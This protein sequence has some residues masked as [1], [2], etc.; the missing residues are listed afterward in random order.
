MLLAPQSVKTVPWEELQE[1]LCNHYSP[2][3]SRFTRRHAFR[4]WTQAEGETVS[5]YMAAVRTAALHCGFQDHLDDMLLDQLV[6]GVRDL[7]LQRH[8]LT[9]GDL[10]LKMAIE[11]SQAAELSM[12]SAAEI[13]VNPVSYSSLAVHYDEA[14]PEESSDEA[15]DVNHLRQP[16]ASQRKNWSTT[17]Q[18]QRSHPICLSCG[19]NHLRASC[20]FRNAICLKCQK[21]GHLARTCQAGKTSNQPQQQFPQPT[22]HFQ[23]QVED[24]FTCYQAKSLNKNSNKISVIIFLEGKPCKM[25]VDTGSALSIIS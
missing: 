19:G 6:C 13:Q 17:N 20:K 4:R 3:P 25:E 5:V 18:P 14:F 2:K 23:K 7:R 15:G 10:T 11:E 16:K 8:L 24:C 22:P 21:K 9:K 1:I 12:L